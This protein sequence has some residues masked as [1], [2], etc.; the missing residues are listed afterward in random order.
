MRRIDID[1]KGVA[2]FCITCCAMKAG[3]YTGPGVPGPQLQALRGAVQ[4]HPSQPRVPSQGALRP[5]P[6]M[7]PNHSGAGNFKVFFFV[8]MNPSA[9]HLKNCFLVQAPMPMSSSQLFDGARFGGSLDGCGIGSAGGSISGSDGGSIGGS[10]D[11]ESIHMYRG[12]SWQVEPAP[13]NNGALDSHIQSFSLIKELGEGGSGKAYLVTGKADGKKYVAK[14]I[15]CLGDHYKSAPASYALQ[16][17]RLLFHLHH[18]H[19]CAL[20]DFYSKSQN[21]YIV[22]EYCEQGDL[23]RH[24]SGAI[25]RVNVKF[26]SERVYTWWYQ[27]LDAMDFCHSKGVLHRD[28]KPKNIFIDEKL[29]VK[30]SVS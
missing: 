26:D 7:R 5:S 19:I 1:I 8:K 10:W 16:E 30:V 25:R 4:Q 11:G 17:T 15:V 6:P 22:L 12:Y 14:Q 9:L 13:V 18:P 24:I 21:F 23:G 3:T 28:L 20:V 2:D 29:N 27:M